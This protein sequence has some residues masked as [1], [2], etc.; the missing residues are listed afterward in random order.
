MAERLIKAG[1]DVNQFT[2]PLLSYGD[3]P[4]S[5]SAANNRAKV[6][7]ILVAAGATEPKNWRSQWIGMLPKTQV[8]PMDLSPVATMHHAYRDAL[9]GLV[10]PQ[11]RVMDQVEILNV[12]RYER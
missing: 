12:S 9:G 2:E 1:A 7:K 6:I 10:T 4:L 11:T 3:T 8:Q 5:I